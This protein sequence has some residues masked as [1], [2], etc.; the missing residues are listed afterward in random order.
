MDYPFTDNIFMKITQ[1]ISA[2]LTA[3]MKANENLNTIKKVAARSKV[4]FGTVQRVKNGD[5]NPTI[6]NLYDIARA[7]NH[8]IE[9]LLA[10]PT[11]S[12]DVITMVRQP[13]A[14]IYSPVILEL[15]ALTDVMD[16]IGQWQLI[17]M[18]KSLAQ[19]H[20]RQK[21]HAQ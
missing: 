10:K 16:D 1:H 5:G 20:P 6:T 7:F 3:W 11:Q 2:N 19:N 21:N 4:G 15:I 12:E 18:A 14:P 9:D 17:G 8:R 13:Q